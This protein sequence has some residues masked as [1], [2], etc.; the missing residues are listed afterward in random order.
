M[1]LYIFHISD[2]FINKILQGFDDDFVL[3]LNPEALLK[4]E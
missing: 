2:V 3:F 1:P 4:G